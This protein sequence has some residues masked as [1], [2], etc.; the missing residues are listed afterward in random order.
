MKTWA[1]HEVD[2]STGSSHS[3]IRANVRIG[4]GRLFRQAGENLFDLAGGLGA[5]PGDLGQFLFSRRRQ[6]LEA[7]E[8]HDQLLRSRAADQRQGFQDLQLLAAQVHGLLI[9]AGQ[10]RLRDAGGHAGLLSVLLFPAR[11]QVQ[12][13]G[14]ILRPNRGQD[15][16]AVVHG[17]PGQR[18]A[19]E[20]RCTFRRPYSCRPSIR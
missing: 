8:V 11:D 10:T 6:A 18:A 13:L 9:A 20:I 2:D 15:G 17:D 5:D 16:N 7:A 19:D 14:R 12:Q 3:R 1:Q 4:K